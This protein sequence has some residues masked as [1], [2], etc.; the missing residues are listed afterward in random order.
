MTALAATIGAPWTV[1]VRPGR[2]EAAA[3]TAAPPPTPEGRRH[4]LGLDAA[5][6]RGRPA[7]RPGSKRTWTFSPRRR[8]FRSGSADAVVGGASTASRSASTRQVVWVL[9]GSAAGCGGLRRP[10]G[11]DD[12]VAGDSKASERIRAWALLHCRLSM[13]PFAPPSLAVLVAT[14]LANESI[15]AFFANHPSPRGDCR[16]RAR[17]ALQRTPHTASEQTETKQ[18]RFVRRPGCVS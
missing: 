14:T 9:R 13:L 3:L 18:D 5:K 16:P 4:A 7:A 2:G 6:A 10:R 17:S 12:D 15:L 8:A 1:P 11:L